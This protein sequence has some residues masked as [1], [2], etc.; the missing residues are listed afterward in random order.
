MNGDLRPPFYN[1][2]RYGSHVEQPISSSQKLYTWSKGMVKDQFPDMV[3]VDSSLWD[4][5]TWASWSAMSVTEERLRQWGDS[6]LKNLLARVSK[7]FHKSRVVFRTPPA[8]YKTKLLRS[9]STG[10]ILNVGVFSPDGVQRMYSELKKHVINGS[11]YGKYEV[12]DYNKIMGD[13]IKERGF[14]DPQLWLK[15]GYHPGKEPSR[16]YVNQILQ[17]MNMTAVEKKDWGPRQTM[18]HAR[19]AAPSDDVD[20]LDEFL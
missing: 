13:L 15:D 5:A 10:N 3:V 7:T 14:V 9:E 16:R 12:L 17:L 11:L 20:D 2:T 8:V 19:V 18:Q 1:K 6:D 4:L